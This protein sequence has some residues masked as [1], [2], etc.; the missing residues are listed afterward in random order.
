MSIISPPPALS[1]TNRRTYEKI[2]RQP[3]AS[4]LPWRDILGLFMVLGDVALVPNGLCVTR[5]G[6]RYVCPSI[7]P[8]GFASAEDLRNLRHFLNRSETPLPESQQAVP[9]LLVVV[10]GQEARLFRAE[11]NPGSSPRLLRH[12][13]SDFFHYHPDSAEPENRGKSS[14]PANFYQPVAE[15][16]KNANLILLFGTARGT[17]CPE[18]DQFIAWLKQDHADVVLR[19]VGTRVVG[20]YHLTESFLLAHAHEYYSSTPAR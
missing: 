3:D 11:I 19:I 8:H 4:D 20:E 12:A 16:L 15:A 1:G 13:P 9:L 2:F 7:P 17:I 18:L 6:H 10:D 14:T 5:Q